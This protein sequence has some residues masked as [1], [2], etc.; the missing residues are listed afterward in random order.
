MRWEKKA[1]TISAMWESELER[2]LL[3]KD[4]GGD[5]E[6]PI[7]TIER[8]DVALDDSVDEIEDEA[9]AP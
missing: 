9:V 5:E 8:V 4:A 3:E 6:G 7:E 2:I 1:D